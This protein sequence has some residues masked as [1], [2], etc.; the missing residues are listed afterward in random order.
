MIAVNLLSSTTVRKLEI[1][2]NFEEKK[3][4]LFRKC[5]GKGFCTEPTE[6]LDLIK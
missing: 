5:L 3:I 6:Q 2:V 1:S 4:K